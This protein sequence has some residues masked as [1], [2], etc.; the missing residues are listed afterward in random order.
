MNL[1]EKMKEKFN[2]NQKLF[3]LNTIAVFGALN[4]I[5]SLVSLLVYICLEE[6]FSFDEVL[7]IN[8]VFKFWSLVTLISLV[9]AFL[10]FALLQIQILNLVYLSF[11]SALPIVAVF[12]GWSVAIFAI[13]N[14]ILFFKE[15]QTIYPELK[16]LNLEVHSLIEKLILKANSKNI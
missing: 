2:K 16:F 12:F 5:F 14:F 1:I 3:I 10:I 4:P 13:L 8:R 9:F 15:K 11:A 6:D 7:F